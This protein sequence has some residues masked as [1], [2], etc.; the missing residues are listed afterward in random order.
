[1][2]KLDKNLS[3][4]ENTTTRMYRDCWL[5]STLS[6]SWRIVKYHPLIFWSS[7]WSSV[8]KRHSHTTKYFMIMER[9]F[10]RPYARDMGSIEDLSDTMAHWNAIVTGNVS[11]STTEFLDSLS[12]F[13]PFPND[14][15]SHCN[16]SMH[17]YHIGKTPGVL[18]CFR[19][20]NHIKKYCTAIIF[21]PQKRVGFSA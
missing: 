20:R 4:C 21:L 13:N 2:K 18:L 14:V 7:A 1:M 3:A 17:D 6:F 10:Q 16:E 15:L 11:R 9:Y 5:H 8:T 19:G 12:L